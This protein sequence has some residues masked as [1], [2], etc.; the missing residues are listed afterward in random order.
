VFSPVDQLPT[1]SYICV[2]GAL[3]AILDL[4]ELASP[5]STDDELVNRPDTSGT[6]LV[7]DVGQRLVSLVDKYVAQVCVVMVKVTESN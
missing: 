3:L 6:S 7:M 5:P 4:D 2:L 1:Q